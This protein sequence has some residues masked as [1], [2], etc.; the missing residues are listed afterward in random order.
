MADPAAP[1]ADR[2]EPLPPEMAAP[3][4]NFAKWDEE[5]L[6]KYL[7]MEFLEVRRD[8]SRMRLGF[9]VE[10]TQP[11]GIMH[12]GAIATLID[13]TVVP[14][15]AAVYDH[16]VRMVTLN[17]DIN[18]LGALVD[19]AAIAEGWVTKRGRSIVYCQ[20]EVRAES[21]GELVALGSLIYKIS[22]IA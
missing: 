18:Y 4:S 2:F 10:V 20:A 1:H 16:R 17:L 11:Q 5:Y 13:T 15:I 8:Y 6:A 9:R 3:W 22:P 12:G 14:A 21:S 19:E 7:G